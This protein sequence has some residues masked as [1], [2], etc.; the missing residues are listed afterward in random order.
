MACSKLMALIHKH[1]TTDVHPHTVD[2]KTTTDG[3]PTSIPQFVAWTH[4]N[5]K[6]NPITGCEQSQ[7]RS[8]HH[9]KSRSYGFTQFIAELVQEITPVAQP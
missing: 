5:S 9:V 6:R 4:P 7:I 8:E 1:M 3:T 2:T